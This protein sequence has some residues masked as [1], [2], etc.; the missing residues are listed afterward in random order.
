MTAHLIS[1]LL[2][3]VSLLGHAGGGGEFE[4]EDEIEEAVT[5][6]EAG[7]GTYL[8]AQLLA[9]EVGRSRQT[10]AIYGLVSLFV[11]IVNVLV[12]GL[13]AVWGVL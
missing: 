4:G 5:R 2:R 1:G 6:A 7:R 12:I 11:L 13:L 9:H 10:A 8:D 3:L